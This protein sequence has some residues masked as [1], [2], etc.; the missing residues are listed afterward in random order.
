[1]IV[2]PPSINSNSEHLRI[3]GFIKTLAEHPLD[4]I[5]PL[6]KSGRDVTFFKLNVCEIEGASLD[7]EGPGSIGIGG[8]SRNPQKKA[9]RT[10]L[11]A[12]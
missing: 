3:A 2:S 8:T 1:V 9:K 4:P 6:F 5:W 11:V 7:S 12:A 10:V